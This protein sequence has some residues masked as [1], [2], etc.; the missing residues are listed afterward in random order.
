MKH[1]AENLGEIISGDMIE[2]SVYSVSLRKKTFLFTLFFSSNFL[3]FDCII[4]IIII[5]IMIINIIIIF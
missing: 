4:I 3:K 1:Q 5:I 2:T